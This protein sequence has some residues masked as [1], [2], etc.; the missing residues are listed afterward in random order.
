MRKH[1]TEALSEDQS[2]SNARVEHARENG[3]PENRGEV[4][5]R[6]N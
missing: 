5:G 1:G 6:A 4:T 3:P 2:V